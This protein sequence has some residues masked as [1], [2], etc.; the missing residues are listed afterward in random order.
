MPFTPAHPLA[1]WP[2]V[3]WHRWLRLDATCLAI[4]AMAPDF[5]YFIHGQQKGN[6]GHTLL[7]IPLWGVPA[8]LILAALFHAIVKWPLLIVAP[9]WIAQRSIEAAARPWPASFRLAMI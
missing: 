3:R 1:V 9:R 4:G 6:F 8:T 5:E 7:G 2:F